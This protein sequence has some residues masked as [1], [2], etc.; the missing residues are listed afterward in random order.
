[1]SDNKSTGEVS[2]TASDTLAKKSTSS[3]VVS[4]GHLVAKALKNEGVDT[5]F[6]LCG[7][8]IIDIYDGCIDEGIRIID[9]RHEQ[10]AAHAA[11]GYARQT[12]RLGCVV[13][14]A[15]PGCTNAVTGVATAFRSESPIL[16]IG[17]QS[18]LTQH[19]MGSLQD[20]PHVDMMKPITKFASGVFSTE[21]IADMI[22]MAARECFSGA[23]GPSYL[24]IPR[25]ILDAEVQTARVVVPKPGSYRSSVKSIGD[26]ADIEK[27]ADILV[28]AERPAVLL[29][30]QVWS[31]RGH[32]DAI[33]FVRALD[34]PAYM[35]GA[36]R[37]MLPQ[38][39][40]HHFD[41]T[42]SD[43]F[44]NADVILIVGTPFDFRMGYG[45]RI[46]KE[47]TLVQV[48]QSYATVGKN[49]D[50][51]LGLAGDPG[52]ILAAVSQAATGRIDDGARQQRQ[53]WMVELREIEAT[54]LDKLM[55]MFTTDQNPIHPYRLAYEINEFLGEDTIYIGDGGDIV[56]ISAQAVRPRNPGQWMDPGALGSLG[57]GTGFSMAAK[58]AHPNKE[59]V[60]LYGD[61][62][63]GM[64]AFDMETAQRFGAPYLAVVGN[65]SAMNQIR[66]GQLSKYGEERGD[67]GNKLGDVPF[68]KFGDMIG[69][70]GEEV[71][72]AGQ[73]QPAM[74]RARE[75]IAKTG[76]CAVVNVWVDP[77]EYAP[78][79]KAQTMYK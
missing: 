12:G 61:G 16:H 35:N 40:P 34:I 58:L 10:T 53:K 46:S 77:N 4:G 41:R 9:V 31:S 21:R 76:K 59:V 69:G 26:P 75:A 36:S 8:H 54:K 79:T 25:D 5:I 55:P 42:R 22:S 50:I 74:Q 73:I 67:V 70:Y 43:A 1:M 15:G 68:S 71:T 32:E 63:F 45:K 30:Q 65:N 3:D 64:T 72:E 38:S 13:T 66:Y 39:D 60:C 51:S 29:G 48:D 18:S 37:G 56:T 33:N 52:A 28:K 11:D 23:Y 7:G 19:K 17:G 62:A 57:V 47:A 20:L 49:R 78:G 44:K 6:T 14:T 24:E 27:L 2:R